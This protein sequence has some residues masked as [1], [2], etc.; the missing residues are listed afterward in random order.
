MAT[1]NTTEETA[2][3][4]LVEQYQRNSSDAGMKVREKVNTRKSSIRKRMYKS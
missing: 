4:T 1:K 2:L 3:D